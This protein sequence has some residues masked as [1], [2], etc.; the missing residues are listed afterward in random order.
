MKGYV[1]VYE[2]TTTSSHLVYT[3]TS[4]KWKSFFGQAKKNKEIRGVAVSES[5]PGSMLVICEDHPYVF[6]FPCHE[7]T[8]EKKRYKIQS[9]SKDPT[10]MAA[11]AS[12]AII[13]MRMWYSFIVLR[14]PHFS[15]QYFVRTSFDPYDLSIS[16]DYLLVMGQ[17]KI[18][19]KSLAG[20]NIREDL[21]EIKLPDG[22]KQFVSVCFGDAAARELYVV[23]EPKHDHY[24]KE[25]YKYEWCGNSDGKESSKCY[26]RV[27]GGLR[28]V[29]YRCLSLT[30]DGMM[31]VAESFIGRVKLFH[32]E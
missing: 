26:G 19:V 13:S 24:S 8:Q 1:K 25:V 12:I 3:I 22:C 21:C 11:N 4:K 15:F 9:D 27:F 10:C 23:C 5:L 28:F 31:A 7:A 18:E 17:A 16:P 14:L 2:L 29:Y 32:L 30:S 20:E 6:E